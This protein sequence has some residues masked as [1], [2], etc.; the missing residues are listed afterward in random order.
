ML[1]HYNF[2]SYFMTLVLNTVDNHLSHG[3]H[4]INNG[5]VR[6]NSMGGVNLWEKLATCHNTSKKKKKV[7]IQFSACQYLIKNFGSLHY[8]WH[9]LSIKKCVEKGS[10]CLTRSSWMYWDLDKYI[11]M[12]DYF[13]GYICVCAI[14][15]ILNVPKT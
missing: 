3:L 8:R 9:F 14:K 11:C 2:S 7:S 13:V 4:Y 10:C 15:I 1:K 5:V 12:F 6:E